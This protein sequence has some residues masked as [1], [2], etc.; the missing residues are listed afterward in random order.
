LH[1]PFGDA[2]IGNTADAAQYEC[3]LNVPSSDIGMNMIASIDAQY[4]RMLL[5]DITLRIVTIKNILP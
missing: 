1:Y 3:D 4:I 2:T 5:T